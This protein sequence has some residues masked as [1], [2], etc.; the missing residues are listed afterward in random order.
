[1]K[2]TVETGRAHELAEGTG[3]E[4][5][6]GAV[7]KAQA[8]G[9][10]KVTL[11][12][13]P[14]GDGGYDIGLREPDGVMVA[15]M[16]PDWIAD[17]VAI[18]GGEPASDLHVTLAYLGDA[19]NLSLDDQR[20]LIG[21]VGEVALDQTE[22]KGELSGTGSFQNGEDTDPYWVGVQ[23]PGLA[24]LRAKLVTALTDAGFHLPATPGTGYTPHVTVAYVPKGETL[25]GMDFA[26]MGVV[27]HHLTVAVGGRHFTLEL[28]H[29][30]ADDIQCPPSGWTPEAISK[31]V[32]TVEEQRYTLG[33]WYVP[34]QLD[35][36]GEWSDAAELQKAFWDYLD[37]PDRDIHL[38][39]HP[40]II[41]GRWRDG[42]VMPEPYTVKLTKADGTQTEHTYPA[43]T[44]F[45]GVQW[46]PWAFELVKK[47]LIRGYS[48]GG[49][50][51]RM[52]VDLPDTG[53]E[54]SK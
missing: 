31:A 54:E 11:I 12:A 4:S 49:S 46:K 53:A 23:I 33:P 21:V 45:L 44:P 22:L 40:K 52:T 30:P 15:W 36:H 1:V 38:Q 10:D 24:E 25:P 39:H 13:V 2:I 48:I 6:V 19:A 9:L 35:A 8:A 51:Q 28:Q 32:D 42:M 41:A 14:D 34:D 29:D 27:M 7:E 43:G 16:L 18:P 5:L 47:G 26:P 50:S 3:L 37:K 17:S 20:K